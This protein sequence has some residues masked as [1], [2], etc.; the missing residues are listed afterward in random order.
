[1]RFQSWLA[2]RKARLGPREPTQEPQ[3]G[4]TG[5]RD[6][7]ETPPPQPHEVFCTC[8]HAGTKKLEG[9]HLVWP[10]V[11][12]GSWDTPRSCVDSQGG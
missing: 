2:N 9:D 5:V 8:I 1:M 4:E 10:A 12:E 11:L 7:P 3:G 6:T